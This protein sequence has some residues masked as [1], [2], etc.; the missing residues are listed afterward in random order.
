MLATESKNLPFGKEFQMAAEVLVERRDNYATITLNRP[1]KRNALNEPVMK[2]FDEAV[3][4]FEDDKEVRAV[5]IRGAGGSFC[6]GI[7]LAE[8]ERLE[9]G[10][11][12]VNIERVFHRLANLPIPTI[13]A[14]QGAA[15][16]G[17]C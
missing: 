10:H 14:V 5:I 8:V 6:S 1:E 12:P 16:V 15:L 11:S 3:T 4:S 17:G 2:A 7:D 9:G 13:A